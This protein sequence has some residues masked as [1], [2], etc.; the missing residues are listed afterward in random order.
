MPK[1]KTR[2]G[3]TAAA[4]PASKKLRASAPV[5]S[6][7]GRPLRSTAQEKPPTYNFNRPYSSGSSS[8]PK[9]SRSPTPAGVKR[10]TIDKQPARRGRP[11]KSVTPPSTTR[12]K[13]ATKSNPPPVAGRGRGRP[14]KSV[15]TQP[16]SIVSS[17]AKVAGK[18]AKSKSTTDG[19]STNGHVEAGENIEDI[20]E[21]DGKQY[22]LMK[23][24]PDS[25]IENG[26]DVKFSIDDLQARTEPEA[27][28]GKSSVNHTLIT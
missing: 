25:R 17:S 9:D 14:R 22:W 20:I 12:G 18:G 16:E 11:T 28:D 8:A 13:Q 10:T 23:A 6:P 15:E 2:G 7:A 21:E 24:E 27:W 5:T 3:A 1:R 4:Q 26:V 19:A